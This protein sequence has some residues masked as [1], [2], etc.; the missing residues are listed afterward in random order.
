MLEKSTCAH[1][2]AARASQQALEPRIRCD[3]HPGWIRRALRPRA[4]IDRVQARSR[5]MHRIDRPQCARI[6]F[7][8]EYCNGHWCAAD[9]P[10]S[11]G[12]DTMATR[13]VWSEPGRKRWHAC[14]NRDH[15]N[16]R[17]HE[18]MRY[19]ARTHGPKLPDARRIG[20]CRVDA[21]CP[22]YP[23]DM[24]GGTE[25]CRFQQYARVAVHD[26]RRANHPSGEDSVV[27]GLRRVPH[28][29]G[30]ASPADGRTRPATRPCAFPRAA[31]L[32]RPPRADS[33]G[34]LMS[35][36]MN[37]C[38]RSAVY[39]HAVP[40]LLLRTMTNPATGTR[41]TNLRR[42]PPADSRSSLH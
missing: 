19:E 2:R 14:L 16:R 38:H 10:C 22:G 6:R 26:A 23:P 31:G 3:F 8:S 39:P 29:S 15:R 5:P 28:V 32:L 13:T 9:E 17:C 34:T 18:S 36:A 7:R 37:A 42:R 24:L 12:F 35:C 1:G 25:T 11:V 30:R 41:A 40:T 21:R 4:S 27:Q 20:R 33:A